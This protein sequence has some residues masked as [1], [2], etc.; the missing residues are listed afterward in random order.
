[1]QREI[2]QEAC[3]TS[4]QKEDSNLGK[5]QKYQPVK[6]VPPGARRVEQR[7]T[8]QA[9][10]AGKKVV[11]KPTGKENLPDRPAAKKS[12]VMSYYT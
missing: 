1:M 5:K 9:S 11:K 4:E 10:A 8:T 6:A 3:P 12:K 2:N 7:L